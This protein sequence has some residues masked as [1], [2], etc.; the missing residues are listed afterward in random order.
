MKHKLYEKTK[1]NSISIESTFQTMDF[2]G[3]A[4][5]CSQIIFEGKISKAKKVLC[6]KKS[7]EFSFKS[8][9][10]GLLSQA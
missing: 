8:G 4:H 10:K 3:Q 6:K 1:A 5:F 9:S 2:K 7:P